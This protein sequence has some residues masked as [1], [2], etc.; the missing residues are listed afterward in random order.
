MPPSP[1]SVA[2]RAYVLA[3]SFFTIPAPFPTVFA[4][5]TRKGATLNS[6]SKSL[7]NVLR[8]EL[9]PTGLP[10]AM[11]VA[12]GGGTWLS[13]FLRDRLISHKE[14]EDKELSCSRW[15]WRTR[16][17]SYTISSWTAIQLLHARGRVLK[18]APYPLT[19]PVG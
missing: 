18:V 19:F 2:I 16:L 10:F 14:C 4:R 12:A 17:L 15:Q 5:L 11:A 7:L 3:V 6:S 13:V 9:G 1:S 8:R